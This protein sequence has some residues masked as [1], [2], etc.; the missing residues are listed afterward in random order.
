MIEKRKLHRLD[1]MAIVGL[2]IFFILIVRLFFL[3]IY[4]GKHYSEMAEGNRMRIFP[5]TAPRG[6]IYDRNGVLLVTSKPGYSISIL[7]YTKQVN[8]KEIDE[9]AKLTGTSTAVIERRVKEKK[10]T[11]ELAT[12]KTNAPQEV[13]AKIRENPAEFPGVIIE[14]QPTRDYLYGTLAAHM[15]G[16]VSE[17]NDNELESLKKIGGGAYVVGDIIGKT[18]LESVYDADIRGISGGKRVEV[19]VSG[20]PVTTL[21]E[22]L[23][24][25]GDNMILTIDYRIQQ[26][27]EQA[28]DNKLKQLGTKAAAV[29]VMNP[30]NGEIL[31]IVS[32]PTF[33]P[34]MFIGGV[35]QKNWNDYNNN[36]F[37]TMENKPISGEYPPGSTFKI[38]TGTAA[39]ELKKITP[40]EKIFDSGQHWLIPKVNDNGEALGWISFR[41]GLS[42]SDNVYF[43]ELGNRLGIDNLEIF[44]RKFG[45]GVPTG[46]DLPNESDGLVA[47]RK[48][49]ERVY[50]EDWYL[51]ETFDAAI[52]QGFNLSTPV[53]NCEVM[54]QIA[55]GGI[56]YKPFIMKR[57][58]TADGA[59]VRE[60]QPQQLS[61]IDFTP[62][63]LQLIRDSLRDVCK[64][65]GT[66]GYVFGNFPI[67][68]AG[69]TGT[70]ENPHGRDHA[71]FVAFAP[72]DNPQLAISVLVEQGG[73]GSEAAAPIAREI[74]AA[75]FNLTE[76]DVIGA[77]AKRHYF[78]DVF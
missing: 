5:I 68:V 56:R 28:V 23:C 61:K 3:Q 53:Q 2:V 34:N 37:R 51:A 13:V 59:I 63:V 41:E 14:I 20:K 58:V 60:N 49:K 78:G 12:I 64:P 18:G 72:F 17:I 66:G 15:F 40:E 45:M 57:I 29:V 44:A 11:F 71:W 76:N 26:A 77:D 73:Y 27:A 48:Y 38:I 32:R 54:S 43:Y 35:S 25:P 6:N 75:A 50:K 46:I 21:A 47:N 70:A 31:A 24:V 62:S 33:D 74:I 4:E 65:G 69:K 19:D 9:L 39:L 55:N 36:P 1:S 52:G 67:S 8:A 42:K 7:P 16:Y 22:K 30:R 10:D